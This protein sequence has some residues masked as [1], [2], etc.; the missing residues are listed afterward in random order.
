M[1]E[2]QLLPVLESGG[3]KDRQLAARRWPTRVRR[4]SP[5]EIGN[6]AA[7]IGMNG[8]AVRRFRTQRHN[9]PTVRSAEIVVRQLRN[10]VVQCVITQAYWCEQ[11]VCGPGDC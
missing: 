9:E 5:D 2:Y 6:R 8:F 4:R 7:G 3:W 1:I 11:R 10:P